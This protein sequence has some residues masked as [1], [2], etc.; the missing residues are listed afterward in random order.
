MRQSRWLRGDSSDDEIATLP[1]SAC[2]GTNCAKRLY[3]SAEGLRRVPDG[4]SAVP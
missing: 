3:V 1:S 4:C 2:R